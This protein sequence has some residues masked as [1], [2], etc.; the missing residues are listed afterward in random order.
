V[1]GGVSGNSGTSL[2]LA[3]E[4][5]EVCEHFSG[6]AEAK[7]SV[8]ISPLQEQT[9]I[10]I[11]QKFQCMRQVVNGTVILHR[12]LLHADFMKI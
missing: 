11:F 1:Q 4:R 5:R 8:K 10:F 7:N 9:I 12:L 2:L 3:R 6:T